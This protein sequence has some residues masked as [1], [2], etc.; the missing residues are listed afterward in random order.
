MK[1]FVKNSIEEEK[2]YVTAIAWQNKLEDLRRSLRSSTYNPDL[3]KLLKN[4]QDMITELS[5]LEVQARQNGSDQKCIAQ[6]EKI[7]QTVDYL[8]KLILMLKLMS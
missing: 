6:N 2:N 1:E 4:I 8:E 7:K 3:Y 5:K